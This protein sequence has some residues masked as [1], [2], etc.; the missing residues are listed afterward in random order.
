[1]SNWVKKAFNFIRPFII[2]VVIMV[3]F[4]SIYRP[5]V[6]DG[7]SMYPT[8]EHND[9]LILKRNIKNLQHGDIIAINSGALHVALC[10]R[11][12][13]MQGDRVEINEN[14]L[15]VNGELLEEDYICEQ[16]W[17]KKSTEINITVPKDCVFVL[18]DNRNNS[19][20]SRSLGCLSKVQILGIMT[21]DLTR[22]FHINSGEYKM[23][24]YIL[25]LML[26]LYYIVTFI[27]SRCKKHTDSKENS[28]NTDKGGT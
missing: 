17:L 3:I 5:A 19:S 7:S 24:L 20:D 9:I 21:L 2:C 1:M 8:L 11:V 25:W 13:G 26:F 18:G 10:K 15:F 22:V 28:S 14:G 23:I 4:L 27:V 6:V 12:I 16:N